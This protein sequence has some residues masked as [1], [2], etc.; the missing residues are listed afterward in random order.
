MALMLWLDGMMMM[1]MMMMMMTFGS[2]FIVAHS[3]EQLNLSLPRLGQQSLL[4]HSL[5]HLFVCQVTCWAVASLSKALLTQQ[6]MIP[7]AILATGT[8]LHCSHC[9]ECTCVFLQQGAGCPGAAS[10]IAGR[11]K[12]GTAA[13]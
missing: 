10:E 1:M 8:G 4:Q 2:T 7:P 11:V 12:Y 13:L 5:R 3:V 6:G 9:T